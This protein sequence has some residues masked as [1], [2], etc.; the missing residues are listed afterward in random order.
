VSSKP[1]CRHRTSACSA[2]RR[3]ITQSVVFNTFSSFAFPFAA[4]LAG[5]SSLVDVRLT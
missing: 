1:V 3:R 5:I 2:L 4:S